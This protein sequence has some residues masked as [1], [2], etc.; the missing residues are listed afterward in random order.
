MIQGSKVSR[1]QEVEGNEEIRIQ[2]KVQA[3]EI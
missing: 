3:V 1:V 2:F